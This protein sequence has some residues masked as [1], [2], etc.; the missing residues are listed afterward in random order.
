MPFYAYAAY[1]FYKLPDGEG[2]GIER[3]RERAIMPLRAKIVS[4]F[5]AMRGRRSIE[6]SRPK[7]TNALSLFL[8][9]CEKRK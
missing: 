1:Y 5:L 7:L 4:C 9:Y 6:C 3:E 2:E 8:G